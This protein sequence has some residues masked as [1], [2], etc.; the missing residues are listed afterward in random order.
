M[1]ITEIKPPLPGRLLVS[2]YLEPRQLS[3]NA[4]ARQ[5]GVSRK[6][7]SNIVN[8]RVRITPPIAVRLAR[9]LDTSPSLWVNLQSAVDIF[10]AEQEFREGVGLEAGRV[11]LESD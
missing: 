8:G 7:L 3:I 5:V 2:D 9:A 4:L 6:H 10:E 1:M 11:G